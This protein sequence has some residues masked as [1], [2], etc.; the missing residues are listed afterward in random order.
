MEKF[1]LG[2][3]VYIVFMVLSWAISVI[4]TR[5]LIHIMPILNFLDIPKSDRHI[6]TEP[7]P[8]SGGLAIAFSTILTLLIFFYSPWCAGEECITNLSLFYKLLIPVLIIIITGLIDDRINI[9]ALVKLIVQILVASYCWY[10]GIRFTIIMGYDIGIIL[11]YVFTIFWILGCINAFNLIDGLDGL[12]AGLGIISALTVGILLDSQEMQGGAMVLFCLAAACLGFLKYNRHPAKIFMGDTGSMFIGFVFAVISLTSSSKLY[13]FSAI[14][15]P[16]L[17][18]GIPIFDSILAIWRRAVVRLLYSLESV[19]GKEGKIVR[20]MLADRRHLHHRLLNKYNLNQKKTAYMMYVCASILAVLAILLT[21]LET[22]QHGILFV[23]IILVLF[24]GIH[25]LATIEFLVSAKLAIIGLPRLSSSFALSLLMPVIDL[26]IITFSYCLVIYFFN[27]FNYKCGI[28]EHFYFGIV[29]IIFPIIL[30]LN[31]S[32][33]YK[34]FWLRCSSND[35]IFLTKILLVCY[36]ISF[37]LGFFYGDYIY[38]KLFIAQYLLFFVLSFSLIFVFRFSLRHIKYTF[39]RNLYQSIHPKNHFKK[40][41]VYGTGEN[42]EQYVKT[43]YSNIENKPFKIIGLLEDDKYLDSNIVY[44]YKVLG[45][46]SKLLTIFNA[47]NFSELIITTDISEE[48]MKKAQDFC[49][50]KSIG[51]KIFRAKLSN[52]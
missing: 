27:N 26:L 20:I 45:N 14:L 30:I 13:T 34:I 25:K 3:L 32:K 47:N 12:A 37:V 31:L 6:H 52:A 15:V 43:M 23:I 33:V 8:T 17:A 24:T 36:A 49:N 22:K 46:I 51:I 2:N 5:S 18:A 50:K 40:V 38:L 39:I 28:E 29:C 1:I 35:S 9:S 21:V 41:L 44:G 11:S 42:C 48:N 4:L 10:I 19:S 7:I 16:I